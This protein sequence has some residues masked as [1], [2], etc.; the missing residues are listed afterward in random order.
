MKRNEKSTGVCAQK[1]LQNETDGGK[2]TSMN[3]YKI[4]RRTE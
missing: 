4:F 3:E 2:G 1:I